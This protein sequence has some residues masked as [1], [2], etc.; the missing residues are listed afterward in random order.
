MTDQPELKEYHIER[1]GSGI[2]YTESFDEFMTRVA[3]EIQTM[4]VRI[5]NV[6][7]SH[8]YSFVITYQEIRK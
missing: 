7:Y 3:N 8:P 4:E 6:R 2:V 5:V 1:K